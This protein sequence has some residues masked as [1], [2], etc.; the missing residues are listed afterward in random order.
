MRKGEITRQTI[1][2]KAVGLA[3]Q[4]GLEGLSIG[5][6]ATGLNLSKSGLFAHF[7]SKEALQMQVL[8]ADPRRVK[9]VRIRP[10]LAATA[11]ATAS[12]E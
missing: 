1:L 6:L 12:A 3:S 11:A 10:A 2:N 9:R 5:G 4:F 7:Q 8:D